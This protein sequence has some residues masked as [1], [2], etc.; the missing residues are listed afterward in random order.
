MVFF[1]TLRMELSRPRAPVAE[2]RI[3]TADTMGGQGSGR[4]FLNQWF[5]AQRLGR[6][7]VSQSSWVAKTTP[8]TLNHPKRGC[9]Q[10]GPSLDGP[11]I[12]RVIK[13][14]NMAIV[15]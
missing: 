2:E 13:N 8:A 3:P 1:A 11:R 7:F 6:N 5:T 15:I 4:A 12:E 10:A 9:V 14:S